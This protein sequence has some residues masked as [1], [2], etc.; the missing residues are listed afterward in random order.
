MHEKKYALEET[1]F[2][3]H[4]TPKLVREYLIIVDEYKDKGYILERLLN[5]EIEEEAAE[6]YYEPYYN[7]HLR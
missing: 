1:A 7:A 5:Y 6:E 3:V 4:K 2:A